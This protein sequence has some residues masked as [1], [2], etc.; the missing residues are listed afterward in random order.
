MTDNGAIPAGK[1]NC[2]KNKI[3][4]YNLNNFISIF[5]RMNS[6]SLQKAVLDC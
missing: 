6:D 4:I 2:V 3:K 5:H 1:N